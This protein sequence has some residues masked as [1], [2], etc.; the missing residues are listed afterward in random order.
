VAETHPGHQLVELLSAARERAIAG[1][2]F[3]AHDIL[4]G[5]PCPIYISANADNL[6][7][8]AL[9]EAKKCPHDEACTWRASKEHDADSNEP[10]GG[11]PTPP[12]KP[13]VHEPL[14]YRLFGRFTDLD[15]VVLTEDDY[16]EYLIHILRRKSWPEPAGLPA[17]LVNSSLM[18]LGFRVEDWSFRVFLQYLVNLPSRAKSREKLHVC[19]QVD[20]DDGLGADPF[21]VRH[22]LDKYFRS[23]WSNFEIYWGSVEDF[24]R[25]LDRRCRTKA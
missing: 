2:H 21:M 11:S 6:L 8:D 13:S 16:F 4:A 9:L 17:A 19:V 14:V 24:L 22:F 3:E 1:K 25:E 12:W 20:P 18:F 7:L 23:S 15:S 10:L 5:L